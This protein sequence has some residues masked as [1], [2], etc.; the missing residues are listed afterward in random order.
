MTQANYL[1]T[2]APV[3]SLPVQGSEQRLPIN[4]LFFV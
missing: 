3:Q 2:P 1:W 4:R